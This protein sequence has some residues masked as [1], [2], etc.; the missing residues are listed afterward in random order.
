M[1]FEINMQNGKILSERLNRKVETND[2]NM[3]QDKHFMSSSSFTEWLSLL[4]HNYEAIDKTT[5][6]H[7][8]KIKHTEIVDVLPLLEG[9]NLKVL[10]RG[11]LFYVVYED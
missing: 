4:V 5:K 6:K 2:E 1:G 9:T 10:T 3:D 11:R 7:N 8:W